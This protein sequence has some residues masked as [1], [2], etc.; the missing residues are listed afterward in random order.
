MS[1]INFSLLTSINVVVVPL[2]FVYLMAVV[3]ANVDGIVVVVC[4]LV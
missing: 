2:D 3:A 1:K 4:C